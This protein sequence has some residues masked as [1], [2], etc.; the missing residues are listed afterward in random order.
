MAQ[1]EGSIG[2]DT[3]NSVITELRTY[4]KSNVAS[5]PYPTQEAA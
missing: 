5:L 1:K 3:E 2:M 4:K